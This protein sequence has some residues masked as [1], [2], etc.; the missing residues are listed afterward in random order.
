MQNVESDVPTAEPSAR[1]QSAHVP[2]SSFPVDQKDTGAADFYNDGLGKRVAY[3]DL[4]AIDW[5]FEYAKERQRL[6]VLYATASGF[7]G[8][9]RRVA[10][11]SHIWL[12]LILTGLATGTLAASMD[13]ASDWLAD[14]KTGYCSAG[15]GGGRFYLNKN[16]CCWGLDSYAQCTDWKPWDQALG[17]S[18]RGSSWIVRYALFILFSVAFAA[19]ASFLVTR[20]SIYAK[21][22]GI[23]EIKTILG[24]YVMRDLM[25]TWTLV[26]KSLGLCLSVASGMWLGKEGPLVH[27][28]CCCANFFLRFFPALNENEARKREVLSAAAAAG[29][30]VAFGAPVGGVLFS[31][32]QLSYYFPDKTMWQSFVCAMIAA[33]TLQAF[34]PFRTGKLV[35]YQVVYSTGWHSF[36]LPIFAFLGVLGGIYGG[37]FIKLNMKVA[38]WRK[39]SGSRFFRSPLLEV[40]AVA[41]LTALINFPNRFMR[42]QSTE[43]VATLFAECD[44]LLDEQ[45]G[46]CGVEPVPVV[47]SRMAAAAVLGFLLT[48]ITFGLAIPAGVILPTMCVGA[49]LGRA[50]GLLTLQ[51]TNADRSLFFFSSCEPDAPCVTAGTY[52]IV[53]AASAL[54]GA[55]RMTV[56]IVVIMF[57]LTGALTY[58]LPIMVSVLISKW[59][60]DAI[61]PRG[62]YEAWIH[63]S[64]YPFLDNRDDAAAASV[65]DVAV[66]ELMTRFE[67]LVCLT[68]TGHSIASLEALIQS[69]KFRGYPVILDHASQLLLGYI[70]RTELLYALRVAARDLGPTTPATFTSTQGIEGPVLDLRPWMDSTPISLSGKSTLQLTANLFLKLGLRYIVFVD[71]GR[72]V[73]LL[74]KKDLWLL[75]EG[76]EL[77]RGRDVNEALGT[78]IAGEGISVWDAEGLPERGEEERGLLAG[79]DPVA[80]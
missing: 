53:G 40:V 36:E 27:V 26:V 28:A 4:T 23:A 41:L 80:R 14:L 78:G 24:G 30:S 44:D 59:I 70:S 9:L 20:F 48:S 33:V 10:D 5:I 45:L 72:L 67:E 73:G 64:Q 57:E 75:L 62:I 15:A 50:V 74:T 46:L 54:A 11:G 19:I 13:V 55:T 6:R 31:L 77:G 39:N 21:Q 1:L 65:P 61:E 18:S 25:G 37:F 43:L 16:F 38:S 69:R 66:A 71:R 56:S 7:V 58:V 60:G 12:I 35:L 29:I 32:E 51:M 63:F 49:L 22:S 47:L 68:A 17:A 34:N 2:P 3:D 52:A 76:K 79:D 8:Y 42:A